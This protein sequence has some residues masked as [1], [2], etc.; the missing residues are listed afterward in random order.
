MASEQ[1]STRTLVPQFPGSLK[2]RDDFAH[3][4]SKVKNLLWETSPLT[5]PRGELSRIGLSHKIRIKKEINQSNAVC[6]DLLCLDL[7]KLA[8]PEKHIEATQRSNVG[9]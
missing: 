6:V 4:V 3:K 1:A 8:A 7:E 5:Q 9:T 2:P